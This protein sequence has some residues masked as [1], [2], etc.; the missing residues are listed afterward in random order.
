MT[1]TSLTTS[2]KE[3]KF[4]STSLTLIHSMVEPFL[5]QRRL[6]GEW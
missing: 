1:Q 3:L 6:V 4:H 2:G 5:Q